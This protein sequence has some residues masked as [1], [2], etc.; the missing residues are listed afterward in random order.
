MESVCYVSTGKTGGSGSEKTDYRY[1]ARTGCVY[2][3]LGCI[4]VLLRP[5]YVGS[6]ASSKKSCPF[7]RGLPVPPSRRLAACR[8]TSIAASSWGPMPRWWWTTFAGGKP[9]PRA[10]PYTG[11]VT[12]PYGRLVAASQKRLR[13]CRARLSPTRTNSSSSMGSTSTISRR[14]S[15]EVWV[16]TGRSITK[17]DITHSSNVRRKPYGVASRWTRSCR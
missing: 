4:M 12:R 11:G 3:R 7:P 2:K 16:S 15:A 9:M 10:V 17:R 14:G 1:R 6:T 8:C 13:R 5:P